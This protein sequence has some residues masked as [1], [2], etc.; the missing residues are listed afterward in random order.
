MFRIKVK[1]EFSAAHR[2]CGYNGDCANLHGHNWKVQISISATELDE[3]G[4]AC[5]FRVAKNILREELMRWDHH[6]LNDMEIFRDSCPTSERIAKEIFGSIS[7][8]LPSHLK[9]ATVEIFESDTS[10]VEYI[11]SEEA[12]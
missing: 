8:K 9:L 11:P 3:L 12:F 2:I 4:M 7:S 5:D 1:G 6:Y 10:S